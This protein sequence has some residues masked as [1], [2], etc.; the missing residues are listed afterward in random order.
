MPRI[1]VKIDPKVCIAAAACVATEPEV[2]VLSEDNVAVVLG[3]DGSEE[4]ERTLDV[5]EERRK[6]I[7]EASQ[8]CPTGAIS[9][10]ISEVE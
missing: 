5:S 2:F 1:T 6:K 7:I 10:V 8:S 3:P 4:S 9:V